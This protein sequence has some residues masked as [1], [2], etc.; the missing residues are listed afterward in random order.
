L[1]NVELNP[2]VDAGSPGPIVPVDCL[3]HATIDTLP[4]EVLELI[5]I[6]YLDLYDPN[7]DYYTLRDQLCLTAVSAHWRALTQ[8]TP[9]LW[10]HIGFSFREFGRRNEKE[11][12]LYARR[13]DMHLRHSKDYPLNVS[14]FMH[15]K[16]HQKIFEQ[17]FVII[18]NLFAQSSRWRSATLQLG[19]GMSNPCK[20]NSSR[21]LFIHW[22]LSFPQLEALSI[23]H[24]GWRTISSI[25]GDHGGVLLTV[26]SLKRLHIRGLSFK[27]LSYLPF[28]F[29]QIRTLELPFDWSR[30][31]VLQTLQTVAQFDFLRFTL[32]GDG[33][34][35]LAAPMKA[36]CRELVLTLC[37]P[38]EGDRNAF[39]SYVPSGPGLEVSQFFERVQFVGTKSMTLHS[40]DA[41]WTAAQI[42]GFLHSIQPSMLD[43]TCLSLEYLVFGEKDLIP[44]LPLLPSLQTLR[45]REKNL[46]NDPFPVAREAFFHALTIPQANSLE[47]GDS[48]A[49]LDAQPAVIIPQLREL[50][51]IL[52][53]RKFTFMDLLV[54]M[55]CSRPRLRVLKV[56]AQAHDE[57]QSV[58]DLVENL[59]L[60]LSCR[61]DFS[62]QGKDGE[63]WSRLK[64]SR[65]QLQSIHRS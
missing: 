52:M 40:Y 47:N 23:E 29:S 36:F 10:S 14:I 30:Q 39:T 20:E 28:P 17:G 1:Y 11:R 44:L 43:L 51:L 5:F 56:E 7:R 46:E 50:E 18:E 59:K 61:P 37:N 22:P 57:K 9:K 53:S 16:F 35:I 26:P 33:G 64:G 60:R 34:E 6:N 12:N 49:I 42:Q 48:S 45:I 54:D 13:V 19:D 25:I 55:V 3:G 65:L 24:R 27:D 41:H 63:Y 21:K 4:N 2:S 32:R 58:Q 62:I 15:V 31:E 8:S 38:F